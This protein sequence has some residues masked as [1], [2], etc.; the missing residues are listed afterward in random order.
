[1]RDSTGR[2]RPTAAQSMYVRPYHGAHCSR[3]HVNNLNSVTLQSQQHPQ[4]A[5]NKQSSR[6]RDSPPTQLRKPSI[7]RAASRDASSLPDLFLP[8]TCVSRTA[9]AAPLNTAVVP[10][11][12][13]CAYGASAA[14]GERCHGRS[15]AVHSGWHGPLLQLSG[16]E[17]HGVVGILCAAPCERLSQW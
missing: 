5:H 12:T 10:Q 17:L 1:M 3:Q 9:L 6:T 8:C 13:P 14:F 16:A 7:S 2:K 15:S 4:V 11:A